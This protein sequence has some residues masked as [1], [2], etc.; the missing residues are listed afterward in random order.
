MNKEFR[1]WLQDENLF[2]IGSEQFALNKNTKKLAERHQFF[3]IPRQQFDTPEEISEAVQAANQ[4]ENK[5]I[6]LF[7][8]IP[9]DPVDG[10]VDIFADEFENWLKK[11]IQY[12]FDTHD[13]PFSLPIQSAS[14]LREKINYSSSHIQH[15]ENLFNSYLSIKDNG[16]IE[17]GQ[18]NSV[19][20]FDQQHHWLQ[21][22]C[23]T[24]SIFM[25]MNFVKNFDDFFK[26]NTKRKFCVCIK[27]SHDLILRGF[28]GII[29]DD[30]YWA[31]PLEP[32]A[33]NNEL[34]QTDL[35]DIRIIED[36]KPNKI[37][38]L[39]FTFSRHISNA[40]SMTF[41]RCYNKDHTF[42]HQIASR[43]SLD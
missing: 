14:S 37:E 20:W 6:V 18:I 22:G 13:H 2:C 24:L 30:R 16:L 25:M 26:L 3:S 19:V 33:F 11:P 8:I 36:F 35:H 39:T 17:L 40:F 38:E 21:L 12:K 7:S 31:E 41:P 1:Q 43:F 28:G 10:T 23:V 42:N 29:N 4:N 32:G 27:N 15:T 34:P 9:E 5:H